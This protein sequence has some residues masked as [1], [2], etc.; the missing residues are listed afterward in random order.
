MSPLAPVC[1]ILAAGRS[2]RMGAQKLLLPF[3]ETTL[4]GRALEAA[5]DL[6]TV[7]VATTAIARH[8]PG[9]PGLSVIVNDESERGMSRS[10]ALAN[11][12]LGDAQ[13]P[14]VVLLADTPLVDAT[15]VRRIL[16]DRGDA[17][18]TYPAR[19][20]VGGH[21]VVFGARPREALENLTGGDTL[22]N[23]RDDPRWN[24]EGLTTWDFD[25]LPTALTASTTK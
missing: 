7:L 3:G 9:R 11:A 5:G 18:V 25:E 19:D 12:A 6:R 15:L 13:A 22:R 21:P 20:G 23:L 24:R 4:L 16:H 10:L 14:L 1:A 8:V 2:E 17:D